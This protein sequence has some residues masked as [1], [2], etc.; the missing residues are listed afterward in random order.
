MLL[1]YRKRLF[2]VLLSLFSLKRST[3]KN[4]FKIFFATNYS[5]NYFPGIER[6]TTRLTEFWWTLLGFNYFVPDNLYPLLSE[7]QILSSNKLNFQNSKEP[8]VSIII[9]VYN[10]LAFTYNCLK[11]IKNN[12]SNAIDFEIILIDDLSNDGTHEYFK[13]RATGIRYIKNERNLGFLLSCNKAVIE[14]KGEFV[15][16]LNNDTQI[17]QKAIESLIQ[18]LENN[19]SIGCV[20]SKLIYPNGLLQEA[21]G[22]IFT[23]ASTLNFG[24]LDLPKLVKYNI[25]KETDYCSGASLMFRKKDF[26]DLGMFDER[27]IPAYYEDTDF[28][29]AI[30]NQL[31][32]KV[33]YDPQSVV[34]HFESISTGKEAKEGN[35]KNFMLINRGKFKEKWKNVLPI[36]REKQQ[37]QKIKNLF[38]E[39]PQQD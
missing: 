3:W 10:H 19:Q 2:L 11:S 1:L 14:A 5:K 15:Y 21:G 24:N 33:I 12:F 30:K 25:Q 23:D 31:K 39:R 8:K 34:I 29:L 6:K 36:Y 9:P 17:Q 22:V 13:S 16:L 32:K 26:K 28:C 20:G 7:E 37:Y 4:F 35:I 27:Y 18:T 38:K